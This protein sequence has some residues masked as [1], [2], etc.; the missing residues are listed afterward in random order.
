MIK[1][2]LKRYGLWPVVAVLTGVSVLASVLLTWAINVLVLGQ[3][4]DHGALGI[5]IAVPAL[6]A[7]AMSALVLRLV[8]DLD[9]AQ[10]HLRLLSY[11][12]ALTGA[13]NRR[14]FMERLQ[15][16]VERHNRYGA[17]FALAVFDADDFKAI[18][19]RHGHP[20]GDEVLRRV[21]ALCQQHMRHADVFA[22]LG[23]EEFGVLMA[24]TRAADAVHLLERLRH[25]IAELRVDMKGRP[26][27]LTISVGLYGPAGSAD[28]ETALRV[29][30][31]ALY[32]A[33]RAGKNR[34]V[35]EPLP[36]AV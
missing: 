19:D 30:D 18:N 1:Q 4:L 26:V 11:S 34:V 5:S 21:A 29:A 23:G 28:A 9:L 31:D 22:R 27:G 2:G 3:A 17:P 35:W 15:Q 6:I 13:Y 16:E 20:G 7:P 12:D 8:R 24:E 25:A 10:E 33:K 36:A 32:A 14:Y